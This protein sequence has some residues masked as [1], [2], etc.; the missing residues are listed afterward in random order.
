MY[1][2]MGYTQSGIT[3]FKFQALAV[4]PGRWTSSRGWEAPAGRR[5]RRP[6]GARASPAP[7][8]Q[9]GAR[10]SPH[11]ARRGERGEPLAL[12]FVL[13]PAQMRVTE[14]GLFPRK[15]TQNFPDPSSLPGKA[16]TVSRA[17]AQLL[18]PLQGDPGSGLARRGAR[19]ASASLSSL[20]SSACLVPKRLR[21]SGG[22]SAEPCRGGRCLRATGPL[23][24]FLLGE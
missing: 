1:P 18:L 7:C 6:Q 4:V 3:D 12:D 23:I 21:A 8:T 13:R 11:S 22:R 17:S 19:S 20:R 5:P 2:E 15:P 10:G 9:E 14:E 16:E 24:G